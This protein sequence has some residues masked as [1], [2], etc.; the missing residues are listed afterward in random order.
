MDSDILEEKSLAVE[1]RGLGFGGGAIGNLY[2]EIADADA[3]ATMRAALEHGVTYFDVDHYDYGQSP[4]DIIA[5]VEAMQAVCT[6]HQV[7]LAAAALQFP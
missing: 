7:P 6:R 3:A 5:R 2:R 1:M 4:A